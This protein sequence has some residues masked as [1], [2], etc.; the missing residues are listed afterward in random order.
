MKIHLWYRYCFSQDLGERYS[1]CYFF[2]ML[3]CQNLGTDLIK[4]FDTDQSNIVEKY[5]DKLSF[6]V[7]IK[8][9]LTKSQDFK[10]L[11]TRY[12]IRESKKLHIVLEIYYKFV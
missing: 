2:L 4:I 12:L 6:Q 11:L 3:T 7:L 5:N 10:I 9:L 1:G 8:I